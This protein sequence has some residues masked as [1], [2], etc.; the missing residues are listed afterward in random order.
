VKKGY[1]SDYFEAVAAKRLSAVEADAFRSNQHEF[2]GISEFKKILG[3]DK[4]KF[5][6]SLIYLSDNAPDIIKSPCQLTWYD[7]RKDHPTR[8]EYRLYYQSASSLQHAK[9]GDLL[10]ICKGKG[11]H[12][13]VFIAQNGSTKEN[14]LIWLFNLEEKVLCKK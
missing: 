12:L 4:K 2:D 11:N 10:I 3:E 8:T 6:S 9:A 13:V 1:L 7:A 14:Q 5:G